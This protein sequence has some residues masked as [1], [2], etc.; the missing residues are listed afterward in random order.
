VG[1]YSNNAVTVTINASSTA[2]TFPPLPQAP[3][4][5]SWQLAGIAILF[6]GLLIGV[7]RRSARAAGDAQTHRVALV[8]ILAVL[9]SAGFGCGGG[10]GGGGGS[11]ITAPPESGNVTMTGTSGSTSH[12]VTIAVNV[13]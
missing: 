8:V 7:L 1:S 9:V 12:T 11:T 2:R 10:S 6:C 4:L 5:G 3:P 13:S